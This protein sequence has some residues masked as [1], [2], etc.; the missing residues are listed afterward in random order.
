MSFSERP[1]WQGGQ[2]APYVLIQMLLFALIL[3]GPKSLSGLPRW[4]QPWSG[5]SLVVGLLLMAGGGLLV[6][7][8]L[9]SLGGNLTIFPKPKAD[10][11]LVQ[12]G[13]YGLVRHP[14]YSGAIIGAFGWALAWASPL[15]LLYAL[16]L[17][18]FFDIKS[19]REEQWLMAR[20]PDYGQY[21]RRVRKLIPFLY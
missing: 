8:G 12:S 19:R 4:G 17:L 10:S 14:I 5:I 16:A 11:S 3:L 9:F 2:G 1:W 21:R 20:Y 7:V 15:A 18:L 13:A 6:V